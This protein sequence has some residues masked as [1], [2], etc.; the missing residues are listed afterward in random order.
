MDADA[1]VPQREGPGFPAQ[2]A[3]EGRLGDVA[4]QELQDW[5]G[6]KGGV[7]AA[8]SSEGETHAR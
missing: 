3:G 4:H 2:A 5:L 7:M 1:V 8:V 6:E